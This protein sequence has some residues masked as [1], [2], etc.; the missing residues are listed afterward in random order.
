MIYMY[1]C[2]W[3]KQWNYQK[4]KEE[5]QCGE[6]DCWIWKQKPLLNSQIKCT[7]PHSYGRNSVV[8]TRFVA[9]TAFDFMKVDHKSLHEKTSHR[10][11]T[12][13]RTYRKIKLVSMLVEFK[14]VIVS[15][16]GCYALIVIL[17]AALVK[18]LFCVTWNQLLL[19]GSKRLRCFLT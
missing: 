12:I 13:V 11:L 16:L 5:R 3:T 1:K 2:D 6:I 17:H 7:W 14:S 19:S 10:F 8:K 15:R 18:S 4:I 9:S